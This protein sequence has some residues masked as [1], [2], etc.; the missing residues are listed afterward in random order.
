MWLQELKNVRVDKESRK[1]VSFLGAIDTRLL[2]YIQM[3]VENEH[4]DVRRWGKHAL[5]TP[6]WN[7]NV[8]VLPLVALIQR[9]EGDDRRV[10]AKE[11]C[12]LGVLGEADAE[13]MMKLVKRE[14]CP[15]CC[16]SSMFPCKDPCLGWFCNQ[17][18][19]IPDSDY[20]LLWQKVCTQLLEKVC[21]GVPYG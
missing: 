11:L 8:W 15:R 16:K 1:L 18:G 5:C 3:F 4:G 12:N 17:C 13:G 10:V 21:R 2:P 6:G 19:L 7:R 14:S 20:A 9:L